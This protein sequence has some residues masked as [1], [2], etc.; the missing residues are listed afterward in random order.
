MQC[1]ILMGGMGSRMA[2]LAPDIPKALLPVGAQTFVEWQLAWLR[3]CGIEEVILALG[4]R[5]EQI[6]NQLKVS[7]LKSEFP[8]IVFSYDGPKQC[9]TGGALLRAAPYLSE[10]FL[11][12]YGDSFLFVDP[13]VLIA[14]HLASKKPFTF[15]IFRNEN[16]LDRSNVEYN[17]QELVAYTKVNRTDRMKYVDYGMFALN[18][19]RFLKDN[20]A[21]TFDIASYMSELV[22]YKQA[23]A[24]EVAMRF[25][26][27][28][29]P[30]GYSAF[31]EF[32]E[33]HNYNLPL[34]WQTF[35]APRK[36]STLINAR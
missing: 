22:T 12:T 7:E 32:M 9:G 10:D 27:V 19:N 1:V 2:Q 3:L 13:K 31:C 30:S 36:L 29:C 28:G 24:L 11:V 6:E 18:K 25:Y 15:S 35:V 21:E 20:Q 33:E 14:T 34:L 8:R 26:E 17:G 16:R 4:I 23:K 5:A